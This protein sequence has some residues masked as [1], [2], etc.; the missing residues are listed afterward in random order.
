MMAAEVTAKVVL[1]FV[2][3]FWK[4][5]KSKVVLA[6]LYCRTSCSEDVDIGYSTN[7]EEAI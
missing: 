1:L 5:G 3:L 2:L 4:L 7:S 6:I